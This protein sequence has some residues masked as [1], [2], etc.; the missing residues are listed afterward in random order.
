MFIHEEGHKRGQLQI[1]SGR[2]PTNQQ[3][4]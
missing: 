1:I 3:F 2:Y 4:I